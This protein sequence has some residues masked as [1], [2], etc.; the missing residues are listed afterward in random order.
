ML[1]YP[2][3]AVEMD[4]PRHTTVHLGRN[5]L[6]ARHTDDSEISAYADGA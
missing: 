1:Y 5:K 6:L 3:D 2:H 4:N